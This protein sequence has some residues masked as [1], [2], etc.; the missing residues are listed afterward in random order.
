MVGPRRRGDVDL[1]LAIVEALEEGG[2]QAESTSTG[3]GL[4]D[5]NAVEGGRV[6]AVGELGGELG[7]FGNTGDA[8][9]LLV[10]LVVN[11]LLLGGADRGEDIRL[12]LVVT[13]G[14]DT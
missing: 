12:A 8:S 13:V 6:G 5:G 10:Q 11:D 7:E 1:L 4:G 3:D 2:A 14:T 9:V